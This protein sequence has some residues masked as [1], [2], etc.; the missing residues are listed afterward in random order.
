MI[1]L[2]IWSF[3]I[4]ILGLIVA[5]SP[6][7]IVNYLHKKSCRMAIRRLY[8]V[9]KNGVSIVSPSEL[10][11]QVRYCVPIKLDYIQPDKHNHEKTCSIKEIVR[12]LNHHSGMQYAIVGKPAS[13]KTTA[14]RYLFCHTWRNCRCVY[15]NMKGVQDIDDIKKQ[16]SKQKA[17]DWKIEERVNAFFDGVDEAISFHVEGLNIY[18]ESLKRVFV[19]KSASMVYDIFTELEL[20]LDNVVIS[21]RP[22][23][24]DPGSD[25]S[26]F[27]GNN[28][29]MEVYS[30]QSMKKSDII[31]VFR[32]LKKLKKLD[33]KEPERRQRHQNHRYPPISEERKYIKLLQAILNYHED[34]IFQYPMFVRY[35]YAFMKEY[36]EN[37][38]TIFTSEKNMAI[39]IQKLLIAAL[40]WEFHVYYNASWQSIPEKEKFLQ[41]IEKCMFSVISCM[42]KQTNKIDNQI[43]SKE[44]LDILDRESYGDKDQLVIAHCLLIKDET[45]DRFEFVHSTFYDYYLAKYLL[46]KADYAKREQ[47]FLSKGENSADFFINIYGQ[48]FC[49]LCVFD[50]GKQDSISNRFAKS[51]GKEKFELSVFLELYHSKDLTICKKGGATLVEFLEYF[52]FITKF[53]YRSEQVRERHSFQKELLKQ[54]LHKGHLD[55]SGTRWNDLS[56]ACVVAPCAYVKKL[57]L[58]GLSLRGY[59]G[60][61]EY[62]ACINSLD[63]RLDT[64]CEDLVKEILTLISNFSVKELWIRDS[65]GD[66]CTHI[67]GI[68]TEHPNFVEKIFVEAIEYSSAYLKLYELMKEEKESFLSHKFFLCNFSSKETARSKYTDK[69][70]DSV[71]LMKAIYE[72]ELDAYP[73]PECEESRESII[74]NGMNLAKYYFH[75][76]DLDA[77]HIIYR[78]LEK[79]V[80][81]DG[82]EISIYFGQ[83]FGN[84]LK[85]IGNFPLAIKWIKYSYDYKDKLNDPLKEIHIGILLFT[86]LVATDNQPLANEV[87]DATYSG[88][89]KL[90]N[91][92][93]TFELCW[94]FNKYAYQLLGEWK[95]DGS[96][97][98]Q[99]SDIL[100]MC[101]KRAKEYAN[102]SG[103]YSQLFDA[104][105]Y[106]LIYANRKGNVTQSGELL[107]YLNAYYEETCKSDSIYNAHGNFIQ[108]L[109]SK[110]YYLLL[111]GDLQQSL[112]VI[113]RLL[114]YP[115]RNEDIDVATLHNIRKLCMNSLREKERPHLQNLERIPGRVDH[116]TR[117]VRGSVSQDLNR[118][119]RYRILNQ[120]TLLPYR[121][122]LWGRLWG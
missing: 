42:L 51:L 52:P 41:A 81:Q 13:G 92:T 111:N 26:Y 17:S 20:N 46:E 77:S 116:Y 61:E 54:V 3:I 87:R 44:L 23:F 67:K 115:H 25:M 110:L 79:Y 82:N 89:K 16:I 39:S 8:D 91:T 108:Y 10:E 21:V 101:Q 4:A 11:Y 28:I 7:Q 85:S 9:L 75:T 57:V 33:R 113:E 45:G 19:D 118:I 102:N 30:I 62:I 18:S 80:N 1:H 94:F 106:S 29:S 120:V 100:I 35:A 84:L 98:N 109:E 99:L 56:L 14:L 103:D 58:R 83:D 90:E 53:A 65:S 50:S 88:I 69:N 59:S 55:L 34:S 119:S 104:T 78:E 95:E 74:W 112:V 66:I 96:E 93:A 86:V 64:T 32:S 114:L 43:S 40:K 49:N 76:G 6:L 24:W 31:K 38:E 27:K 117:M 71:E 2:E 68:L 97:P 36:E 105:Y 121:H 37:K 22:E 48:L 15:I 47:Y 72:L 60:I 107:I 73:R 122:E 12:K 63:I 70:K 5:L